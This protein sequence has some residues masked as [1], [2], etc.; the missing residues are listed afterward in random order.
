M[1]HFITINHGRDAKPMDPIKR[2]IIRKQAMRKVAKSRERKKPN[3]Q[4]PLEFRLSGALPA[5][6]NN[7]ISSAMGMQMPSRQDVRPGSLNGFAAAP[8]FSYLEPGFG[9]RNPF[10]SYP[11]PMTFKMHEIIDLGRWKISTLRWLRVDL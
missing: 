3:P 5:S 6:P 11:V 2:S 7:I 8:H 4:F 10:E 9:R 1:Y